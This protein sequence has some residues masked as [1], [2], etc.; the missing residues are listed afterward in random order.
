MRLGRWMNCLRQFSSYVQGQSPE[1]NIREYFYFIDH[2]GRLYLDDARM[3]NFTS[4]FKDKKFLHFFFTRVRLN[5][6]DRYSGSFPYL[7]PCGRE[8]NFI[9]CDDLPIVYTHTMEDGMK[10]SYNHA[11]DLLTVPFQPDKIFMSPDTGRVYHPAIERYGS[12]GLIRS[13][14]AIEFSKNFD[15]QDGEAQ[16]PTHFTWKGT[17][18]ELDREWVSKTILLQRSL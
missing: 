2:E 4:C 17:K 18:F 6:T 5:N 14:L 16:P 8:R 11:G 15:F 13:K 10:L 7:S 3:K 9:R 1:K 12:I